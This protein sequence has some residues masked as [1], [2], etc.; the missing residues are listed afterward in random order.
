MYHDLPRPAYPFLPGWTF[1]PQQLLNP[2]AARLVADTGAILEGYADVLP[3]PVRKKY[4]VMYP[5]LITARML[6]DQS[7]TYK[8]MAM[9]NRMCIWM[10]IQDDYYELATAADLE[11]YRQRFIAL[12][13][14]GPLLP[15]DNGILKQI[16]L[17]VQEMVPI[18]SATWRQRLIQAFNDYFTYGMGSEA[19][20]KAACQCPPLPVFYHIREYAVAAHPFMLCQDVMHQYELPTYAQNHPVIKYLTQLTVRIMSWEND[21]Y[22]LPKEIDRETET[23]NLVKVL[24]HEYQLSLEDAW[25]EAIRISDADVKAFHDLYR[26]LPD[27]GSYH[28]QVQRYI[29]YMMAQIQGLQFYYEQDTQRYTKAVW[30]EPGFIPGSY[31]NDKPAPSGGSPSKGGSP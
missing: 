31:A 13:K 29:A 21:F 28:A 2:H 24:Q 23:I 30:A 8:H 20:Y 25:Q 3:E 9:C 18:M 22:T 11:F 10:L 16:W 1:T 7:S 6:P 17:S 4:L 19:P 27:F 15:E 12:W 26:V 5:A 14:G